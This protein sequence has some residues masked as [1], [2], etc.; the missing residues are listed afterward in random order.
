MTRISAAAISWDTTGPSPGLFH[1]QSAAVGMETAPATAGLSRFCRA[2]RLQGGTDVHTP[3]FSIL[4]FAPGCF[5]PPPTCPPLDAEHKSNARRPVVIAV[6]ASSTTTAA[7]ATTTT[8]ASITTAAATTATTTR[9]RTT[10]TTNAQRLA[11]LLRALLSFAK[12]CRLYGR[13]LLNS[14]RDPDWVA[15]ST[16]GRRAEHFDK[17]ALEVA[18]RA[19]VIFELRQGAAALDHG[20]PCFQDPR[21]WV[22][23]GILRQ[24][25][26]P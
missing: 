23:Q 18:T 26:A 25:V 17:R 4:R 5:A 24:K 7:A 20:K 8:A 11:S 14:Q 2:C 6:T 12:R 21:I 16:Q 10:T 1:L 3:T 9:T 22:P 15:L 19:R 13:R